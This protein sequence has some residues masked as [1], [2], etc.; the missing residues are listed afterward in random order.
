VHNPGQTRLQPGDRVTLTANSDAIHL[1]DTET[2][3]SL[4]M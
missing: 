3:R 4:R 2:T 1:F